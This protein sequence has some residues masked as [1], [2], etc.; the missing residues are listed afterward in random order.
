MNDNPTPTAAYN[1]VPLAGKIYIPAKDNP[2]YVQPSHDVPLADGYCATIDVELTA[3]SALLIGKEKQAGSDNNP[4]RVEFFKHPDGT[5]AIP[6]SSM[7]GMIRNVLEI[8]TFGK[9]SA[10]DDRRLAVRDLL[11]QSLYTRHFATK[12]GNEI[13]VHPK[14]AWLKYFS[15]EKKWKLCAVEYYRV[16]QEDICSKLSVVKDLFAPLKRGRP[17]NAIKKHEILKKGGVPLSIWFTPEKV[18]T[19]RHSPG[20]IRYAKVIDIFKENGAKKP[21]RK[22]GHLVVTGQTGRKHME[23]VFDP[24]VPANY[25]NVLRPKVTRGFLEIVENDEYWRWLNVQQPYGEHGI[26]VFYITE[27][28]ANASGKEETHVRAIGLPQMFKL[29]YEHSIHEALKH[30]SPE[31]QSDGDRDFVEEL[32]GYVL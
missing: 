18:T 31:H 13:H 15:Q 9:M 28:I 17:S 32:F 23:F 6:G 26:P 27:K 24:P 14:A 11:N 21:E 2:Q 3:T 22:E 20:N 7:R 30:T 29:P 4:G 1:F 12:T 19:H 5:F 8:A 25:R 10:V 16:E